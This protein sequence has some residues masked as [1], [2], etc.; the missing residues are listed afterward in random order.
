M[1]ASAGLIPWGREA[2]WNF[3][4]LYSERQREN[5]KRTD[6]RREELDLV[7]VLNFG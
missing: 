6:N 3:S 1:Y 4:R 7:T 5:P 2:P